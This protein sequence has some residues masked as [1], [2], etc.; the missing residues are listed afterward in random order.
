MSER[1]KISEEDGTHMSWMEEAKKQT[2]ETMPAFLRKLTEDYEHD[3][4]T[5]CH[6]IA[7]AAIGAAWA[8]ER[9]PQGGITGF[10]AG[11]IMWEIIKGWGVFGTGPMRMIEFEN[12]LYPQ[13]R[14]KFRT[15]TSSTWAWLQDQAR[16]KLKSDGG[17]E[18][19]RRH[20]GTIAAGEVPF[21]YQVL[22]D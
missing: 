14:E 13:Y 10:Q 5:I 2:M 11:C 20:W 18:G 4:G 9:S 1:K 7:A 15:I 6:A 3:Y 16:E 17:T 12:M 22:D 21:G 8:V 19:V